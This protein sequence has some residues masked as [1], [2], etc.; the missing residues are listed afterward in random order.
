M[1]ASTGLI[2]LKRF[3]YLWSRTRQTST[4]DRW[5]AEN[6]GEHGVAARFAFLPPTST[7]A[8]PPPAGSLQIEPRGARIGEP[9]MP[10]Q[11]VSE[12]ASGA[13]VI[14]RR[15]AFPSLLTFSVISGTRHPIGLLTHVTGSGERHVGTR[16]AKPLRD[17]VAF[18]GATDEVAPVNRHIFARKIGEI[19]ARART[20]IEARLSAPR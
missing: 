17:L 1:R 9:K 2:G 12:K 11:T 13:P 16:K 6:T 4:N 3:Q 19:I 15:A 20:N 5:R 18:F 7:S 14:M 8:A 10:R